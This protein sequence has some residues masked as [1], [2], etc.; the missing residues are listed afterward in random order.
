MALK[1]CIPAATD[2]GGDR[3]ARVGTF[4]K[5]YPS[6][7]EFLASER[8]DDGSTRTRGTILLMVEG[9]ASKCCLN[10]REQG[11]YCFISGAVMEDVL[12]AAELA[13]ETDVADWRPSREK[14]GKR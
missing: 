4:E 10:D 7:V 12:I 14:R 8:W 9:G 13:I 1:R 6:I 11:R 5:Q 3:V 2:A